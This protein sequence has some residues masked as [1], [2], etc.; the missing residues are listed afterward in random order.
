[1]DSLVVTYSNI[2]ELFGSI[3][4]NATGKISYISKDFLNFIGEHDIIKIGAAFIISSQINQI[5]ANFT[6][7]II[8]PVIKAT[9]SND[10]NTLKET[11]LNILGIN[12]ELGAF[13][14]AILRFF[15]TMIVLYYIFKITGKK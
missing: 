4:S 1:M 9:I 6:E 2:A 13:V 10:I 3:L 11:R 15:V 5:A 14:A 12:F 8:S 7:N